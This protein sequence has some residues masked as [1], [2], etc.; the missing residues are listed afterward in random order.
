MGSGLHKNTYKNIDS[1]LNLIREAGEIHIRGISKTLSINPFIVT[2][3]IE[4]YLVYF[5]EIRDIE[6]FGFRIKLVRFKPGME[7]T[8]L[9]QVVKYIELRRKIRNA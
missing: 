9:E 6:Q 1:M 7:N 2:H 4:K 3:I 8:T 5:L